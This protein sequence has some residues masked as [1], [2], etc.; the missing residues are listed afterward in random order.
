MYRFARPLG[1]S[2]SEGAFI[3]KNLECATGDSQ[4]LKLL[5]AVS[6]ETTRLYKLN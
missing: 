6:E 1:L 5:A 3:A 2:S 4:G